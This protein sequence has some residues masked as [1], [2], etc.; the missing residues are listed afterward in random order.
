M[1]QILNSTKIDIN[2]TNNNKNNIDKSLFPINN[3]YN[4]CTLPIRKP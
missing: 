2:N 1:S 4:Q 3:T